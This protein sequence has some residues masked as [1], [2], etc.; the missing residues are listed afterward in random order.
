MSADPFQRGCALSSARLLATLRSGAIATAVTI[1]CYGTSYAADPPANSGDDKVAEVTVTGSRIVRRDYSSPSPVVTV[2]GDALQNSSNVSVDQELNKLPQVVPGANQFSSSGDVQATATSS[3]GA[4]TVNLRGLGTNRNLVLLD[5]RR[6]QPANASLTVDLNTLPAAAIDSVELVTGGAAA[7]Y[8]ADALAGVINFKLKKHFQGVEADVQYGETGQH[9]GQ[10]KAASALI[11]GN[12]N[13]GKGNIML[14]LTYATRDP[15]FTRDRTFNAA[16]FTDPQS[17]SADSFQGFPGTNT[18]PYTGFVNGV[19][20]IPSQAAVNSVFSQFPAG[21]VLASN[22]INFNLAST[23]AGS[24]L[25]STI[26]GTG[27]QPVPGFTGTLFPHYK[28]QSNGN[29]ATNTDQGYLSIPLTRYSAFSNADYA[30]TDKINFNLQGYLVQNKTTTLS[31][32]PVPAVRQW[33]VDIPYDAAHPV[34]SQLK[35]LLDSRPDPT[36][37][38]H[39]DNEANYL[40]PR[41]LDV[42]SNTYQVSAGLNGELPFKDWTWDLYGST[43][44]TNTTDHYN[45]F[46][47]QAN[48]QTL[49]KQ[50]NYGAGADFNSGLIGRLAHCTSGL[51]PFVNTP[52]SQDCINIVQSHLTTTTALRQ[53]IMELNLQGAGFSLPAG[54]A[55]FAVGASYRSDSIDY[56][57]DPGMQNTNIASNAVGIF[58]TAPVLGSLAVKEVYGET[59]LPVLGHLP[60]VKSLTLNLGYR[61]SSYDTAAGT[62]GTWKA[63]LD[64]KVNDFVSFRGGPQRA[65]RAPNIAEMFTPPT[66]LVTAWPDSDPCANTTVAAYGNVPGNPNRAKVQALCTALSQGFPITNSFSGLG[67]YFPL[68]LDQVVGNPNVKSETGKTW[69][70]GTVLNSPFDAAALRQ[71]SA[72]IDYYHIEIDGAI[73]PLTS[74]IL[75]AQCLNSNGTSNPTYDPNNAACQL[76][77]RSPQGATNTVTARYTNLGVIKTAGVDLNLDWHSALSDL[78][79]PVPGAVNVNLALNYIDSY[80]VQT[81]VGNPIVEYKGSTGFDANSGVQFSWKS[82]LTLGYSLGQGSVQMRWRHL[83]SVKNAAKVLNPTSLVQDDASNDQIDL[84]AVWGF[85]E[86]LSVRAGVDNLFDKEPPIEGAIPGSTSA[87]GVTNPSG[88]YDE[89]GRRYFI[90]MK[91]T[92]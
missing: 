5:G 28:I 26:A 67:F 3:P 32:G 11:G 80:Q 76:I 12:I 43:G 9:D 4:A 30:I 24:T 33:G 29:L 18:I 31:G 52:V 21:T 71:L 48:Y 59:D 42:K 56:E 77:S 84:A 68:A 70:L 38:W 45:G 63:L 34:P 40:G 75:Y 41:G 89:L 72:T 74:Q 7:T 22:P 90:G 64:W 36:A 50:P 55:R 2:S 78:S 62:V 27:G 53:R 17:A 15:V 51:N 13:D 39:L 46:I 82:N 37:T 66:V 10:T 87:A 25:F 54:E 60:A 8:G 91:A 6:A 58:G 81:A 49:I 83:P 35:T 20:N 57:P 73:A 19:P 69:T 23:T 88:V 16:A 1:A 92:F 44:E 79:V 61:H 85:G 86:H 47:D 14:G 65:N